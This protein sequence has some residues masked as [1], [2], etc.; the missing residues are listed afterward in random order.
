MLKWHITLMSKK[1]AQKQAKKPDSKEYR[2]KE[3]WKMRHSCEHVLHQAMIRLYPRFK[4]AMGPATD[5]GFYIDFDPSPAGSGQVLKISEADFPKIEAEMAKIIQ[6][7]LPIKRKE[8]LFAQAQKLF[9][10]NPYKRELLAD[11]KKRGEKATAYWTGKEFVSLC[12]GPHVSS[13][14]KIGAFKLLSIAGAYWHGSEKN[15]MLTRIYGTCFSTK[16]EL[17]DY[18]R[19]QQEAEKRD[20]RKL[21][22]DLDLFV[23]ADIIGKGLPLLTPKGTVIRKELEK[24]V[25]E[26]E[27][28]RGYQHVITPPLAKVE[29]YEKSGHYPY[30]KDTMYPAMEIDGE[31]LILRPMTCPHHFMLYK[32]QLRSYKEL[33]VRFAEISPQFRYEKSGEL[34]GLTRVRMFCLADAHIMCAKEQA[35]D[36]IKDVLKLIDYAN[37]V[38]GLKKGVDYRYRL[39]LGDR[40][41]AKK[42]YKDDKAWNAAENILRQVL[43]K[44]KAPFYEAKGEAAFYGPKIDIQVKKVNGQEETAFTVQ[45]DFVMPKRF[46]LTYIDK[47]GKEKEVIVIHRSS[48]GAFERTMAL[49]IEYYAGA[50]PVW[51]SPIQTQV[52]PV[53]DR[54]LDYARKVAKIIKDQDIRVELKDEQETVSKK[55][56]NGELQKIPY[57]LVVGDREQ[58]AGTVAVRQRGKGDLG[59][60]E[61][62]A[63]ILKV[64]KEIQ[65]KK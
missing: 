2:A 25:L 46:E 53:A 15:K 55:I 58:K 11:I 18:L 54:H 44:A 51:L 23:F 38:F 61:L 36:E 27:T 60:M 57:L 24:F 41:D 40:K 43:K 19:L 64:K 59:P 1:S 45:Y 37:S 6:D 5:E 21:G 62:E 9:K 26:E 8:L 42:Y 29:L 63:F 39:S 22:K 16:K 49:L 35:K 32:S 56:R 14:G 3:L 30:Y 31:K 10:S 7:N 12:A 47:D 34:S 28:K 13:T 50:F 52:I 33:P 65:E 17:D 4:E 20:H 48:I